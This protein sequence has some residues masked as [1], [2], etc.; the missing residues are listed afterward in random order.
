MGKRIRNTV[1]TIFVI[2]WTL[3]FH[4]ESTC[5]FYLEPFFGKHLP[6][7]KFLFPPAGWIMFFNVGEDTGCAEVYGV[8][9]EGYQLIDP[10]EILATRT[11]GFDNIHR[12]VLS[13]VLSNDLQGPFCQ[14]LQRKFSEFDNFFVTAVYYPSVIKTPH[15]RLQRVMYQ[16]GKRAE[17]K[18]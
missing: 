17:T 6:K 12:N 13:T 8:N 16:C 10:H 3:L 11:I 7:M 1:I 2:L 4:Y 5:H 14:F 9:A 18:P 15:K